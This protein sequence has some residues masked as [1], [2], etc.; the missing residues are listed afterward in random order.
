VLRVGVDRAIERGL[1][2]PFLPHGL[3]HHLGLQVHDVGGQQVSPEGRHRSPSPLYPMLRTTRDLEAGHVVT[4][5][6][7]LYFIPLLLSPHREGPDAGS[8]DWDVVDQLLPCGGIRVE[9]DVLVTEA[10]HENLTRGCVP[11]HLDPARES[12]RA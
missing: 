5:E 4:V 12:T 10:G 2:L 9:D 7:G 8:F 3:G 6:P 1:A 11:G